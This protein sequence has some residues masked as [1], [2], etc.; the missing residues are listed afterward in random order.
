M[1]QFE[2]ELIKNGSILARGILSDINEKRVID[3]LAVERPYTLRV[4]CVNDRFEHNVEVEKGQFFWEGL[5]KACEG[6]ID[7]IN[8]LLSMKGANKGRAGDPYRLEPLVIDAVDLAELIHSDLDLNS[9]FLD[10]SITRD[11][12]KGYLHIRECIDESEDKFVS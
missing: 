11:L 4:S 6:A 7:D 2:I 9:Y 12:V 8:A 5:Y 10:I 3:F 1:F